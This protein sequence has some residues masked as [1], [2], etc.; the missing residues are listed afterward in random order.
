MRA[1]EPWT[2]SQAPPTGFGPTLLRIGPGL[3]LA[4][5]IV[6][7]GELIATTTT[8]AQA[9][10]T[11]LWLVLAGCLE[12]LRPGR[13]RSCGRRAGLHGPG[14]PGRAPRT[15]AARGLGRV[16]LGRDDPLSRSPSRAG[17]SAAWGAPSRRACRSPTPGVPR[18]TAAEEVTELQI[19]EALA[20]MRGDEEPA[21]RSANSWWRRAP[22]LA[23]VEQGNDAVLWAG[24]VTLLT[25][26]LLFRAGAT[27][28]SR[29][30]PPGRSPASPSSRSRRSCSSSSRT[31]GPFEPRAR[32]GALPLAALARE[33]V[34][35]PRDGTGTF[36]M[37]GVGAAELVAYP[38]WCLEKGYA[39]WTGS[40][41]GS[42]PGPRGRALAAGDAPRR[43]VLGGR[44]H[45]RDARLLPAGSRR[46]RAGRPA[47]PGSPGPRP[48]PGRHVRAGLRRLRA[49]RCSWSGPSA[50]STRPSS[51]P[52]RG[53]LASPPT[54]WCVSVSPRA[55]AGRTASGGFRWPS[56]SS[57]SG[58]SPSS[59]HPWAGAGGRGRPGPP[60]PGPG[61]CGPAPALPQD[62]VR[63]R[64][65]APL[66]HG[67]GVSAAG[68]TVAGGW[69]LVNLLGS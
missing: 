31:S 58:S 34:R 5:S 24:L 26:A 14:R 48:H 46:P 45:L 19:A 55:S 38:Y 11:L 42:P 12:G 7:S 69:T 27:T 10:F 9:G 23:S 52:P 59:R 64:S 8:G 60:P 3:V 47:R 35:P 30:S 66:G 50:S 25:C 43:L 29:W 40:D 62:A 57:A 4:G 39:R 32:R 33:G 2:D 15:A 6:G 16:G 13:V 28:S 20:R 56:P 54:P 18:E 49:R 67:P 37:I 65:E 22:E 63:A 61:R 36:G 21:A 1:E 51:W 41:D 53:W 44:L 17:S 68:F